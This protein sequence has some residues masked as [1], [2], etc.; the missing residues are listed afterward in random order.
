M[1]YLL[2][3]DSISDLGVSAADKTGA[4]GCKVE[5]TLIVCRT[6][7]DADDDN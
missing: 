6:S 3:L 4:Y 5:T 2:D 7:P 1:T